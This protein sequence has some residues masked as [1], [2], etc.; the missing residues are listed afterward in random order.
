MCDKRPL[1]VCQRWAGVNAEVSLHS[2]VVVRA[3]RDGVV[4]AYVS[5]AVVDVV[6]LSRRVGIAF[7][8]AA[9]AAELA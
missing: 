5:P 9:D 6:N 8:V 7:D 3:E 1:A 2:P 4:L